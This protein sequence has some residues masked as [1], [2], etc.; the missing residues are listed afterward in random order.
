VKKQILKVT[1]SEQQSALR[2][3][4]VLLSVAVLSGCARTDV[5]YPYGGSFDGKSGPPGGGRA[6]VLNGSD[7]LGNTVIDVTSGGVRLSSAGGIDNSTST[8]EG[9]RTVRYG[10]GAAAIVAGTGIVASQAA[11][12]YGANQAS[13][14]TSNA[15]ASKAAAATAASKNATTIRLA[16][17]AAAEKADQATAAAQ[18]AAAAKAIPAA[19]STIP[20]TIPSVVTPVVP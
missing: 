19:G 15:A 4:R 8:R 11:N 2:A 1:E 20:S 3:M 12:A 13:A 17:I 10:I 5:Y 16:E 7:A 9:Y 6:V 14:A 18:A